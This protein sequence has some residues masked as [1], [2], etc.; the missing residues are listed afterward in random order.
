[1]GGGKRV[2]MARPE[3]ALAPLQQDGVLVAGGRVLVQLQADRR[4]ARL[5]FKRGRMLGPQELAPRIH[6]L[7]A[8]RA[9]DLQVRNALYQEVEVL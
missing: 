4:Q 1:M 3:D 5:G 9:L 7:A 6:D 8:D 2:E